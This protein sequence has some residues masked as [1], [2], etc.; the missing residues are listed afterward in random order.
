MLRHLDEIIRSAVLGSG[1]LSEIARKADV[2][3][4]TLHR[5]VRHG[6]PMA[7]DK[8]AR[9][10]TVLNMRLIKT[11]RPAKRRRKASK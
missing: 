7:S 8:L 9:V 1:P 5:F 3:Q 4:P 10:A 11:K 2:A 6:K